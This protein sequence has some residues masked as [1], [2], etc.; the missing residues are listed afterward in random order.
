MLSKAT[1]QLQHAAN[2][3]TAVQFQAIQSNILY[4]VFNSSPRGHSSYVN[5]AVYIKDGTNV[6]TV[7]SDGTAKLWEVRTTECLLTIR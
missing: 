7:S 4:R 5:S 1:V 2:T 3:L 6:L